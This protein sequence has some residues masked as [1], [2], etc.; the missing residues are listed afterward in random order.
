MCGPAQPSLFLIMI[1]DINS[2]INSDV[3]LFADDTRIIRPVS[4]LQDVEALQDD[5]E[6]LYRW[7][8]TNNMAF[9]SKKFEILRYGWDEELKN[10]TEY[11]PEA[12]DLIERK[13]C[14]RDLG[15]QMSDN[16]K[17]LA[18]LTLYVAK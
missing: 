2:N 3:S 10:S 14:L 12:E 4:N 11:P 17:F 16:G 5:L 8:E 18:M 6:K 13:E 15:I 1:N 9:N 7:Q